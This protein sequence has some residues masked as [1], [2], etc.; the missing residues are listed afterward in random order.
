MKG[1]GGAI[2]FGNSVLNHG[3]YESG[4]GI[5][6]PSMG[7]LGKVHKQIRRSPICLCGG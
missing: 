2:A 6:E 3:E 7:L 5:T 4:P 1:E